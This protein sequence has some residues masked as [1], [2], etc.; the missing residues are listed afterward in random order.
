MPCPTKVADLPEA[1]QAL[2]GQWES[3][4][5][6]AETFAR[7]ILA[8]AERAAVFVSMRWYVACMDKG[9]WCWWTCVRSFRRAK[10]AVALQG[11]EE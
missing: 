6:G 10:A 5:L 4:A 1:P 7:A 3:L 11:A 2:P 8:P 9:A